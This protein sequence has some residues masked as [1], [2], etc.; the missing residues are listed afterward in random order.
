MPTDVSALVQRYRDLRGQRGLW[1]THWQE[2][3]DY[4]L[5][6]R[7]DIVM[8]RAKGDKRTE[9]LFDGTALHAVELLAAALHGLLTGSSTRWFSLSLRDRTLMGDAEVRAWLEDAAEIIY[10]ELGRSNFETE[11][12]ELYL[13]L[14][15]F[16]TSCMFVEFED[17]QLR[18]ATRHIAEVYLSEDKHGRID[19]VFRIYKATARQMAQRFGLE[20]LPPRIQRAF[21]T[22]P[23][24]EVDNILHVVHPRDERKDGAR[25]ARNMPIA[26]CYID[27]ASRA[28][29][30]ES[31]YNETPFVAPRWLK[32]SGEVYGRSPGMTALPD[33][34]VVN[35]MSEIMLKAAAKIV[36]PPIL[37]PD[38]GVVG[39]WAIAPGA[40][41]PY[42]AGA[43]KPEPLITKVNLPLGLELEERR[44][45]AINKAFY[46]DLLQFAQGPAMTATEVVQRA[47]QQLRLLGPVLGRL[48]AELLQ[49]MIDRTF[50]LLLRA[51]RIPDAP[52]M[53]QGMDLKVEYQ[54]PL[55]RAQKGE[56]LT[57]LTRAL[58]ILMPLAQVLPV[59]DH[60]D[61]DATVDEVLRQTGVPA[62][63]QRSRRDVTRVRAER[64]QAE[65]TAAQQQQ[66][67]MAVEGAGTLAKAGKDA[68]VDLAGVLGLPARG[69]GTA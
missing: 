17:D 37:V 36:D 45:Q 52:Q 40:L 16:G 4:M 18:F 35:K 43:D 24:N 6:R 50:A 29:I 12:H 9:R 3:A 39:R 27:E 58:Q 53:L 34:K 62:S 42:R 31:G 22:H 25:D 65:Q 11:L 8:R 2:L 26:S 55:A 57:G 63:V 32:A 68:D 15:T 64:A 60:I 21:E 38:D 20:K 61:P 59:M 56:R 23:D 28:L 33:T 48:T 47:E 67:M 30:D 49:P 44:R 10:E 19:S 5:P 46:T 14:V 1:E 41:L 7:A 66:T 51:G 69:A 54:S 13:D